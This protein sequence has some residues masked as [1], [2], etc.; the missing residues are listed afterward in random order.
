MHIASQH[1]LCRAVSVKVSFFSP[2]NLIKIEIRGRHHTQELSKFSVVGFD[3]NEG[4]P[5]LSFPSH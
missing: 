1:Y 4:F 5:Y 3:E 2:P